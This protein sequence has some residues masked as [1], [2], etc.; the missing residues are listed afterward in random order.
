MN[1]IYK[2]IDQQINHKDIYYVP[3]ANVQNI[4]N[5]IGRSVSYW[6]LLCTID[7]NIVLLDQKQQQQHLISVVWKIEINY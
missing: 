5:V 7:L 4:Y 1:E 6:S 3:I 2:E